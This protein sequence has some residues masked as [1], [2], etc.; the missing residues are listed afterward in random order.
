MT[1]TYT[2]WFSSLI[3]DRDGVLSG[4]RGLPVGHEGVEGILAGALGVG[5]DAAGGVVNL[6]IIG[7]GELFGGDVRGDLLGHGGVPSLRVGL[8]AVSL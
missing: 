8:G 7:D 6:A 5:D 3:G 1:V 4:D 2:V